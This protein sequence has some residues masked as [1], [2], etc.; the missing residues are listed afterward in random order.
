MG[1]SVSGKQRELLVGAIGILSTALFLCSPAIAYWLI[2]AL[3]K[4]W[5]YY[6][7]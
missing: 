2:T 5:Y 4:L 3:A 7:P 1:V 6:P